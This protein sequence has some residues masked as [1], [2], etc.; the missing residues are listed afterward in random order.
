M[1]SVNSMRILTAT[2]QILIRGAAPMMTV[3]RMKNH[4]FDDYRFDSSDEGPRRRMYPSRRKSKSEQGQLVIY[5]NSSSTPAEGFKFS[6]PL[7]VVLYGS[8]PAIHPTAPLVV[9]PLCGGDVLLADS[10]GKSYFIRRAK[11]STRKSQPL[12]PSKPPSLT[13]SSPPRLRETPLLPL[14]QILTYRLRRSPSAPADGAREKSKEGQ[15]APSPFR[16]RLAARKTTRCPPTL[17]HRVKV[18]LDPTT[19]LSPTRMPVEVTWAEPQ[20]YLSRSSGFNHLVLL[21][22]ELF[23]P[24][25]TPGEDMDL[26]TVPKLPIILPESA[27]SRTVQYFP[28][29]QRSR[30]HGLV[31]IGS[32]AASQTGADEQLATKDAAAA[33]H[34]WDPVQ[35][36]PGA[37]SPPI[38]LWLREEEDLGGWG[39]STVEEVIDK[40]RDKGAWK[41]KMEIFAPEDDCDLEHYFLTR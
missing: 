41:G 11:P 17:V 37:V 38:G 10:K 9:W 32:W 20:V 19:S 16:L 29:N 6:H 15:S 7:P 4:H 3:T 21:R 22:V 33:A 14:R 30:P 23:P 40:N 36:L 26:V 2:V 25:K 8:P 34:E 27:R 12:C 39:K 13:P 24:P 31:L 5:D 28:P 18:G 35:G 1:V